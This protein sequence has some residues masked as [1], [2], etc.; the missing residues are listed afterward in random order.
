MEQGLKGPHT[1]KNIHFTDLA[2]KVIAQATTTYPG[3]REESHFQICHIIIRKISNFQ[4]KITKHAKKQGSMAHNRGKNKKQ[5]L[6]RRK[7]RHTRL[8]KTLN[9][10]V[11]VFKETKET[12]CQE[13]KETIRT[14]AHKIEN[15]Q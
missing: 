5:K 6:S 8:T 3:E 14:I 12:M 11:H 15:Y 13:L 10:C 1:I 4:G 7:P 9:Q 2:Q